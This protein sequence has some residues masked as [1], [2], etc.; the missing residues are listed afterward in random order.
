M[1]K[2]L[3]LFGTALAVIVAMISCESDI[4][5]PDP[6]FVD[7]KS[8]N[9]GMIKSYDNTVVLE[10]N[11]ALSLAVD[12]KM[13]PAPE[14]RIYAMVTLAV[15]DALNNVVPRYETYALDNR[16][17]SA[18]EISKK[19]IYSIADAAV[20]Q[21][22]HD[23]LVVLSPGSAANANSL[24]TETLAQ[25][26]ESEFKARGIQI[27]KDAAQAVLA[28]RQSDP[29]LRF[30]TY[31]QGTEPGQYKSF[32]PYAVANPP[33]WPANSAYAPDMGSF[34][35]F[36]IETSDQF[37]AKPPYAL[38]SPEYTA[39]FNEV[40]SLGSNTSTERTQEQADM[41]VFFLDNVSNSTN[42]IARIM[43]VQESLD[44]WETARLLAL[45]HMA[46]F[47]ACLSS[48]EGKYHYNRWRPITA[49]RF[50]NDDGNDD[51][52][53]DPA[54]IILQ[55]AR[56]TP[57]TPTY[58]S[59]HSEMGGAG[60]EIFRL[61]FKK[62]NK[63]FTIGSYSMPGAERSFAG[64][65]QFA[66]E[67]ATSRIYIGYHFRSDIVEGEKMGRELGKYVFENN[68]GILK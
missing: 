13:P 3:K 1:K 35:P 10:W 44:G 15:H 12:N 65:S 41:G 59:T 40:K 57:P 4:Q 7:L 25:I 34:R 46:Q 36:G 5:E 24:L 52:A 9:N 66:T 48:F 16:W 51:T 14:A 37:R 54:W 56:A 38:N 61:F 55:A 47:D 62:D 23:V 28:D 31:P 19:N 17:V 53:G 27:G 29:P 26:E 39:D 8:A 63:P 68:L 64:F 50:G 11:E 32:L 6:E 45:T 43:A 20:A 60:A 30:Q 49:I 22:A 21:A 18:K 67:C 58:P 2:D 42:R 33:V